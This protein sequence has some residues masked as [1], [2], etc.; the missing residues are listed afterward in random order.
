M[1]GPRGL[2]DALIGTFQDDK[3]FIFATKGDTGSGETTSDEMQ[4][5]WTTTSPRFMGTG[6]ATFKRNK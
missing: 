3:R 2:S 1:Q 4:Y 5:C 6:C